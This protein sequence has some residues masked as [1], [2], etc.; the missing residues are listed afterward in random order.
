MSIPKCHPLG[1]DAGCAPAVEAW[2]HGHKAQ[3][4]LKS[5]L[6]ERMIASDFDTQTQDKIGTADVEPL[7]MTRR[8]VSPLRNARSCR[9]YERRAVLARDRIGEWCLWRVRETGARN[10]AGA[11]IILRE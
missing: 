7:A 10:V 1:R 11:G 6:H 8:L 2:S 9:R 5:I 3:W 4:P